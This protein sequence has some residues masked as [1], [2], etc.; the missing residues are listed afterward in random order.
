M[1]RLD[2]ACGGWTAPSGRACTLE[3][4]RDVNL[5]AAGD[6]GAVWPPLAGRKRRTRRAPLHQPTQDTVAGLVHRERTGSA[7]C[8][9]P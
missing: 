6:D 4:S 3:A 7:I 1:A 5:G 8:V 2:A 9:V